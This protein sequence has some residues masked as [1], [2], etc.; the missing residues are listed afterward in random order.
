MPKLVQRIE[1]RLKSLKIAILTIA[2][3]NST[4]LY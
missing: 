4:A 1:G 2:E 3:L